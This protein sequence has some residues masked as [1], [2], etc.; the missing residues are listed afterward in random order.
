[1]VRAPNKALKIGRAIKTA[2]GSARFPISRVYG[3][4][5][6]GRNA[7]SPL[8]GESPIVLLRVQVLSCEKLLSKDKNG[9]SDPYVSLSFLGYSKLY[10]L[11]P[12]RRFVVVSVLSNRQQTPVAKKT[13]SPSYPSKDATFDFPLYLSLAEKLGVIE[14]VVWD[15]DMLKKDYLGEVSV[16]LEDWFR[17]DNAFAF[18]DANNKVCIDTVVCLDNASTQL[19][20]LPAL[21]AWYCVHAHL[22]ALDRNNQCQTGFRTTR[23]HRASHGLFGNIY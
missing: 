20:A 4:K 15:K 8:P 21:F 18:D 3:G 19:T 14:L 7:F 16:P 13:T 17:N 2:A 5:G 23:R 6:S 9:A 22:H 11:I 1:M 10:P 12:L